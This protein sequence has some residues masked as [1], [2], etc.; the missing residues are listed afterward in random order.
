[1][2]TAQLID[3]ICDPKRTLDEIAEAIE[4]QLPAEAIT[5]ELLRELRIA[6]REASEQG[7]VVRGMLVGARLAPAG[8]ASA[9]DLYGMW[10]NRANMSQID[11]NLLRVAA[12]AYR[13]AGDELGRAMALVNLADGLFVRDD[14][15]AAM[16]AAQAALKLFEAAQHQAGIEKAKLVQANTLVELQQFDQADALFQEL[17][18]SITVAYDDPDDVVR[19]VERLN[20]WACAVEN[21]RDEF[22]WAQRLYQQAE[23]LLPHTGA[24]TPFV[25]SAFR[26]A[27]NQG[28]LHQR[29]GRHAEARRFFEEATQLLNEGYVNRFLTDAD[30]FDLYQEQL[31]LALLLDDR[32]WAMTFLDQLDTLLETGEGSAKQRAELLRF[33]AF[34]SEQFDQVEQLMGKAIALFRELGADLLALACYTQLAERAYEAGRNAVATHALAEAQ[35]LLAAHPSPRRQLELGRIVAQHDAS[36][37]LGERVATAQALA[38]AGDPLG[39]AALWEVVGRAYEQAAELD[40][41]RE[42]YAQALA[43]MAQA[44]GMVRLSLHTLRLGAT[45]RRAAERS[46]YLAPDAEAAF[47]LS[48]QVRAQALLDE[49]SNAGLW[50]LLDHEDLHEIKQA[51]EQLSYAQAS[52]SLRELRGQRPI[53]AGSSSADIHT[54]QARQQAEAAYFAATQRIADAKIARVGWITGQPATRKAIQAALPPGALLVAPTLIGSEAQA[55]LWATVL[56]AQGHIQ[57]L[58]LADKS[59][60]KGF[61]R[62]WQETN[63]LTPKG[64]ARKEAADLA[65]TSLYRIFF[66]PLEDS[67]TT[68][69]S[70]VI[71]LDE[72]MPLYPLHAAFD[73]AHYLL[74]RMPVSYIPSGSLLTLLHQRHAT[75]QSASQRWVLGYDA[76]GEAEYAQLKGLTAELATLSQLIGGAQRHGPFSPDE[77]LTLSQRARS[78]HLMAHGQFPAHGSGRFAQLITGPRRLYADDLYRT[79]L[80]AD[81]LFLDACHSGQVGPGM[82]GF[83]GAALVSGASAVI[84]AMWQVQYDTARPLI[85]SFYHH[86]RSGLP[87]AQALCRAQSDL[88]HTMPAGAWA[89]F[90]LTGMPELPFS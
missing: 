75:R 61:T 89:H 35:A 36:M 38:Q 88:A 2:Q 73:R 6:L 81:L 66:A 84:A 34:L 63:L 55:E 1:M 90:Y 48:E 10:V 40:A 8:T 49:L 19:Y 64:L 25:G 5:H 7:L 23:A 71:A 59:A 22:A 9:L 15:A 52:L 79:E 67:L 68:A 20:L 85:R 72:A 78:L 11:L 56:D 51:Y 33:K 58:C 14:F 54:V 28:I 69:S 86:W 24:P 65:L 29:I 74:E 37:P 87:C 13:W 32:P 27:L 26:L 39:A 42:A 4:A 82:Q 45:R 80:Q 3:L 43:A 44:R 53:I 83:I 30:R 50:R 46:F 60:W 41:A 77:L 47:E 31:S 57:R 62:R 12:W 21:L 16:E 17:E 70:L 76:Q 18:A